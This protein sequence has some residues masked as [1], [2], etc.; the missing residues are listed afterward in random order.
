MKEQQIDGSCLMDFNEND[1]HR[2]GV[3]A[4]KDKKDLL[5]HIKKLT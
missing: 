1:L 5:K 3:V 4:F 2:L